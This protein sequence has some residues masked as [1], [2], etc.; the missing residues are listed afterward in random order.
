[1]LDPDVKEN[2]P[3]RK[4]FL[5]SYFRTLFRL[6]EA[7]A[8]R[9]V[10]VGLELNTPDSLKKSSRALAFLCPGWLH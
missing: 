2:S 10:T 5:E 6:N 7:L 9:L 3:T 4:A 8:M 1:M